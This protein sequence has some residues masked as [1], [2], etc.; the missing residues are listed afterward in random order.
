M[1]WERASAKQE[2]MAFD[3]GSKFTFVTAPDLVISATT[4]N[5]IGSFTGVGVHFCMDFCK[6]EPIAG[7][8]S[9]YK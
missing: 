6:L 4:V 7:K 8:N 5:F 3:S 1:R 9:L 2:A